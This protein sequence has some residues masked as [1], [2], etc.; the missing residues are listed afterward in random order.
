MSNELY[1]DMLL[2]NESEYVVVEDDIRPSM[3]IVNEVMIICAG[4]GTAFKWISVDV[5][6]DKVHAKS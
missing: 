4:E 5:Y 3:M 1:D 6:E 2:E